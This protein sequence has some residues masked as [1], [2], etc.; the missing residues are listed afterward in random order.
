MIY[1]KCWAHS[2]KF[3]IKR[4]QVHEYIIDF[5]GRYWTIKP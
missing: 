3:Q 4:A 1:P 2:K 5:G